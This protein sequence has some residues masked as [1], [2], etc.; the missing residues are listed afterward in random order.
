MHGARSWTDRLIAS[1]DQ[2]LRTLAAPPLA[3]RP[4]PAAALE[5]APLDAGERSR[6]AALLR[7]NHAGELAAQALYDAQ[8]LLARDETTRRQLRAAAGEE[9]DHLA[10]CAERL[11]DLGGR[12]SVL[13]PF[14]YA[15]SFC[16]GLAAGACGD[17]VSLGFV[18]E[19]ERQVEGHL[20]DHL[21]RLPPADRKS[22]AVLS[23]MAADEML[24]GTMAEL[25]GGTELPSL[26]RRC[27]SVGG[28]ILRRAA[29][30]L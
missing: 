30:I 6:S 28:G 20:K 9:R 11:R 5:E 21:E 1:L 22:A 2:G 29:M 24:H 3:A 4:S 17:R 10:W 26:V 25:A 14:W 27:M 23:Q 15:G 12:R 16:I 13:D 7:V 19:T 8:A 18:T